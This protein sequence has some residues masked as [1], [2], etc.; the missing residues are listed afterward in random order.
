MN[1]TQQVDS[2]GKPED[3][4]IT[5]FKFRRVLFST[6]QEPVIESNQFI[7]SESS[8]D[9]VV[10][11]YNLDFTVGFRNEVWRRGALRIIYFITKF[12]LHFLVNS[13]KFKFS[14]I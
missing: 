1:F 11:K 4:L 9:N 6:R 5:N 13:E 2:R 3:A 7:R 12:I 14:F 10:S 8:I